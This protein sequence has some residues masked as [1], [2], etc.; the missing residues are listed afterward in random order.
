[1]NRL[2]AT[3]LFL[4]AAPFTLAQTSGNATPV[5]K[6]LPTDTFVPGQ[7][8]N[9]IILRGNH[10]ADNF[11]CPVG[12]VAS[13]QA[14]L[15]ILSANDAHHSGPALGLHL[16]LNHR[17]APAIESIE[18]TVYGLSPKSRIL[19]TNWPT[20]QQISSSDSE[21]DTITRTLELHRRIGSDSLTE[22]DV[23]V[24][25]FGVINWVDLTSITYTDGTTWQAT[26]NF[27]C[28]SVPSNL[29]LV[30]QN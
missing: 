13:R 17:P 27:K 21:N 18:I 19:P 22:S 16:T 29:L 4:L 9:A 14:G 26:E 2:S 8:G 6:N 7:T 1:M 24:H 3:L 28:R 30:G 23:W 20:N 15:Q 5:L 12:F 25:Q 10:I 11:G